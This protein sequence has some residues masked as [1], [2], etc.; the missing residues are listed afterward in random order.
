MSALAIIR[1]IWSDEYLVKLERELWIEV[2]RY[3]A[4]FGLVNDAD[5]QASESVKHLVRLDR[6]RQR[7]MVTKHDIKARI[8]EFAHLSGHERI[9]LGMTS[10]D[11]VEN[12]YQIR[13]RHSVEFLTQ[14]A[15][16]FPESW[17]QW[18]DRQTF[19]GIKGPVGTQ[20]DM[21]E[22]F[23]TKEAADGLDAH[24]A[25]RFGFNPDRVMNSAW[26]TMPR[27]VDLEPMTNLHREV[28]A[29][30]NPSASAICAG[31]VTMAAEISGQQ[32]NE[33]DVWTSVVRRYMFPGAFCTWAAAIDQRTNDIQE[34]INA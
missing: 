34:I 16:V 33:G 9:H 20:Q 19:R 28:M 17:R 5:I 23:G 10:A 1:N 25:R 18:L 27:S 6:I 11:I 30:D 31:F 21:L 8:E 7:E 2:M 12:M 14:Y 3:Q 13:I 29:Y 4:D 24:L 15:A 22:L 26:Q 32:W